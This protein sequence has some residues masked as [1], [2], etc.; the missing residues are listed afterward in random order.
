MRQSLGLEA[1]G[2]GVA[3]AIVPAIGPGIDF[4]GLSG[5]EH[6]ALTDNGSPGLIPYFGGDGIAMVC[7]RV[8]QFGQ[9]GIDFDSYGAVLTDFY[10]PVGYDFRWEI[11]MAGP[12]APD[13]PFAAPLNPAG[14]PGIVIPVPPV[15]RAIKPIPVKGGIPAVILSDPVD[16]V[17]YCG[18][19]HR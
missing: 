3:H 8:D 7:V 12:P 10:F 18:L 5:H 17:F 14:I 2:N 1:G 19:G 4:K 11:R 13:R 15:A 9:L 6:M 16:F